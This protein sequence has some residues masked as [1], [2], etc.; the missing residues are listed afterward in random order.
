MQPD[1][2]AC[3]PLVLDTNIVLDLFLFGD[4]AT[5][6]LQDALGLGR[7]DWIATPGMR[8]ELQHV[9]GYSHIQGKLVASGL[10][11]ADVLAR[12]DGAARIVEPAAKAVVRCSDPDDQPFIDLA[13]HHKCL[14]LS[15]DA[16]VLKLRKR[17]APFEVGVLAALPPASSYSL[18]GM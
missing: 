16:A 7:L 15:K 2:L 13:V 4:A 8:D 11:A 14:L 3:V 10:L 9:L 6:P 5:A 17:L 18:N 1:P 12:F